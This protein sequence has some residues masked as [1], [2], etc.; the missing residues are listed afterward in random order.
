MSRFSTSD[1]TAPIAKLHSA[2][3]TLISNHNGSIGATE[4]KHVMTLES[5]SEAEFATT[6]TTFDGIRRELEGLFSNIDEKSQKALSMTFE[7]L[8][9]FQIEAASIAML[10]LGD[11][12]SYVSKALS[13]DNSSNAT[14]GTYRVFHPVTVGMDYKNEPVYT[15]EAYSE[16]EIKK[17]GSTSVLWNLLA[18]KQNEFAESFYP[19]V[20]V[21]PDQPG[22]DFVIE[23]PVVYNPFYNSAKGDKLDFQWRPLL[24]A[25]YD[26]TILEDNSINVV[27]HY[28][29]AGDDANATHFL[30]DLEYDTEVEKISV[31]TAPLV[32]GMDHNV[33]G[34]CTH[35]G[36][37]KGNLFDSTDAL[38]GR[39]GLKNVFI[40]VG[41][42]GV[43]AAQIVR[44]NVKEAPRAR[45]IASV[46]GRD[47]EM[48]LMYDTT[49][50]VLTSTSVDATGAAMAAENF[51][52]VVAGLRV[53]L[54]FSASGKASLEF[55][56]VNVYGPT[57]IVDKIYNAAGDKLAL[58]A[59]DGLAI[60]TQLGEM[61]FA[62]F[63]L[64]ARRTNENRRTKGLQVQSMT[65]TE[66]YTI[67]VGSPISIPSPANANRAAGN[68][69]TLINAARFRNS[70]NAVTA[71]FNYADQLQTYV[72]GSEGT[73]HTP[74]VQG[75]GRW[76]VKAFFERFQLSLEDGLNSTKSHEKAADINGV[77]I[78]AIRDVAYRMW[79]TSRYQPA[80][81]ATGSEAVKPVLLIGCDQ[82]LAR[83]IQLVGDAR[84]TG[85]A[86]EHKV[87]TTVDKRMDG[88]IVLTF[89]RPSA[90]GQDYL[91]FGT[92]AWMPELASTVTLTRNGQTSEE[93]MV[94]PRTL[95]I[96]NL[97]VMAI[98]QVD[99][100]E[101]SAALKLK[102]V[103]P[104]EVVA[105]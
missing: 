7:S 71:M 56:T 72:A 58:D 78:N 52:T 19:T 3:G 26:Y 65:Y 99:M 93:A 100:E 2:I 87:V 51:D 23:R 77:L 35:P 50:L 89:V 83:H 30:G 21:S 88:L 54:R 20:I 9:P 49:S 59:G 42:A 96:N 38:D 28:Q 46:E 45:F 18:P 15:E 97:P 95:H 61:Q 92:H 74:E 66:R 80:M 29:D 1:N 32:T 41:G 101:L 64:D 27:P 39:I 67:P 16:T 22:I 34:L 33:V 81:E 62:G 5:I 13:M 47:R 86:I 53:H 84:T 63:E 105:P 17:H 104:T 91:T 14:N 31:T 37:L 57:V 90:S 36:L 85:I 10:G 102:T 4:T 70:N 76:F 73:D 55:G 79:K 48:R 82:V 98:I 6:K 75:A 8:Q 43:A 44:F 40:T 94:Q 68:L 60:V 69:A 11:P 24:D 12:A 25:V 103:I